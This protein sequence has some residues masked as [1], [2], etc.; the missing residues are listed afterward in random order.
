MNKLIREYLIGLPDV[1]LSSNLKAYS[2]KIHGQGVVVSLTNR[3]Y[4][5]TE[6]TL[7]PENV[8]RWEQG[9]QDW[10]LLLTGAR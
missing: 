9:L 10:A 8:E 6:Y 3:N 5:T 4:E 7:D 1:L 2:V